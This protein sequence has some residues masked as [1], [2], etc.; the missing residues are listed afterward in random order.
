MD[1]NPGRPRPDFPLG[2]ARG[3]VGIGCGVVSLREGNRRADA[4]R[5]R[6]PASRLSQG[7]FRGAVMGLFSRFR[8]SES[9]ASERA[10]S[11]GNQKGKRG[12]AEEIVVLTEARTDGPVVVPGTCTVAHRWIDVGSA[13]RCGSQRDGSLGGNRA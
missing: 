4:P 11:A 10:G 7:D 9:K 5:G 6:A 3:T 8:R 1:D 12:A 13:S 2:G